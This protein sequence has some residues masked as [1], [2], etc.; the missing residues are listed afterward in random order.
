[1][2][3]IFTDL[4]HETWRDLKSEV[5]SLLSLL[6]LLTVRESSFLWN[7]LTAGVVYKLEFDAKSRGRSVHIEFYRK[8]ISQKSK[9]KSILNSTEI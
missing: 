3:C 8:V 9:K 4:F 5:Y 7:S 1:M 2:I 6:I